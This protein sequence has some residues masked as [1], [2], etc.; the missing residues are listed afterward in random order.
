[1]TRAEY[2]TA[3]RG[4]RIVSRS[5]DGDCPACEVRYRVRAAHEVLVAAGFDVAF[6]HYPVHPPESVPSRLERHLAVGIPYR[7][8]L[9]HRP[10]RLP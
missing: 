10:G 1:M 6:S 4:V 7:P 5:F 3:H 9:R 8:I 2:R